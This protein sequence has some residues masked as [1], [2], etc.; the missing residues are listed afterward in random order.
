MTQTLHAKREQ[1]FKDMET[2][3]I[4]MLI[5]GGGITGSGLARDAA[6][7]GLKVALVEKEDF[8][9][10]TSSRSAK[11]VHGGIRYLA[12]G[13]ISMVRESARERKTLKKIAPHLIHS[14]PFVFPLYKGD[15]KAKFRIGFLLF[16]KL[17]SVSKKDHHKVLTSSEVRKYAP[18]LRDPLKG[19]L[20]YSE[21]VTEDARF[22][23]INALSAA[24]HG[25]LVANHAKVTAIHANENDQ[26]T[27]ATVQD[28]LTKHIYNINAKITV[29]ATG[30]WA[31]QTLEANN[32]T[33]KKHLLLSKGVH[34]ILP[35]EKIPITGAVALKSSNNQEGY[36]IRRGQHVYVGTTDVPYEGEIDSPTADDAAIVSLLDMAKNCFPDAG[37]VKDDIVGTWAGMRPLIKENGKSSR[38]TSRHDE[39][40]KTKEGLLTVAGG[41]LTTY[42]NMGKRV[43]K[44]VAKSLNLIF[45]KEDLTAKVILPGGDIGDDFSVFKQDIRFI[46]EKYHIGQKTAERLTWFYGSA[47]H[48]LIR[49]GLEDPVWFE[50]LNKDVPA[51]KGEV[52]H[53][54]EQEMA[55]TLVDFMDRRAALVLFGKDQDFEAAST[56]AYIMGSFL[57]WDEAE[58]ESQINAY[59]AHVQRHMYQN[60][61]VNSL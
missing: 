51:I 7:R 54:V 34:L 55:L 26:V 27:G 10:G 58:I 28:T 17:A 3:E 46:L 14:L 20:V 1:T 36:A 38:D 44:E 23:L 33:A 9:F 56:A 32:F 11:L 5:I 24:E 35:A 39:V 6:L 47:V 25:A 13:E 21:Y 45:S 48:D 49:Y 52:K 19:G 30:P 29:N 37:L 50:P 22:T 15:S 16:D 60:I 18:H 53:A 4:D 31:Q 42:R 40:W 8:G 2:Q 59:T 61:K 12:N 41:K 43:M 57:N